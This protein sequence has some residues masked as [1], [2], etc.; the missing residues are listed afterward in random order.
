MVLK[1]P[2]L[3]YPMVA[4]QADEWLR[5]YYPSLHG[6]VPIEDIIEFTLGIDI[7]PFPSLEAAFGV[8]GTLGG[9]LHTIVVD[10]WL[11]DRQTT[12]YR[13]TLAHEIGHLVLHR[14]ILDELDQ[15]WQSAPV[16]DSQTWLL[17]LNNIDLNTFQWMETQANWWANFILIPNDHFLEEFEKERLRI[18]QEWETRGLGT[19]FPITAVSSIISKTLAKIFDVSPSAIET[20]IGKDGL[21]GE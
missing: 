4:K 8:A 11:L 6:P 15:E 18:V 1:I 10:Q 2:F 9:G 7:V 16:K 19:E 5:E 20:R 12:R 3:T 21:L 14:R 13:F 17:L